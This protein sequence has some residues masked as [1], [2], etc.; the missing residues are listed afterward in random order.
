[1]RLPGE[2]NL[3][4]F[5][6]RCVTTHSYHG[7]FSLY[8]VDFAT[9]SEFCQFQDENRAILPSNARLVEEIANLEV[10][11]GAHLRICERRP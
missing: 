4:N 9:L 11:F 5:G 3:Q 1:M 2:A 10:P 8:S 7:M 6:S